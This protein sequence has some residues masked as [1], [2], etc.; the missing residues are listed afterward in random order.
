M[1][2]L[3]EFKDLTRRFERD[4]YFLQASGSLSENETLAVRGPSGSGKSTLLKILARLLA[5]DTGNMFYK[6]EAYRQIPPQKWRREI[7]YLSQKPVVFAGSVQDNLRLPFNL[8]CSPP[9]INY[10][11]DQASSYLEAVG[12]STAI[13]PQSAS[14]LSGGEAARIALIRSLLVQPNILL[15]DEPTAYL[16]DS[17]AGQVINLLKTWL[18]EKDQ[19]ALVIVSH[20]QEDIKG[21]NQVKFLDL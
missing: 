4:D 12:L 3:M 14:T 9:Q 16:D 1:Q 8:N 5:P 19:R 6:G 7:Q 20:K 21:F 2:L 13:L 10:S 15:L 18:V 17:S 11:Q